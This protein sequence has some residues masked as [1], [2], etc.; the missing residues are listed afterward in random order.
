M[1]LLGKWFRSQSW[2]VRLLAIWLAIGMM[3]LVWGLSQTYDSRNV[4]QWAFLANTAHDRAI[5]AEEQLEQTN[6]QFEE[7][8]KFNPLTE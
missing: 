5:T 8:K 6:K 2:E 4:S 3:A 7:Y 1:S